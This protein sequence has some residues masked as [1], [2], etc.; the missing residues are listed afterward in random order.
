MLFFNLTNT[1]GY[2]YNNSYDVKLTKRINKF[3]LS[4]YQKTKKFS[5]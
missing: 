3:N 5:Y 4:T 1:S 2:K